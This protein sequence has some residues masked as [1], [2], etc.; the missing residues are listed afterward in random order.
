MSNIY[1]NRRLYLI[2]IILLG[3]LLRAGF[4]VTPHIDSDQ[5]IFGLQGRHILD[6]EFP[7]FSWGY[8]YMGTFQSYLDALAFYIFGSSRLVLNAVTT[9]LSILFII[10]TYYLGKALRNET[11]GI[12]GAAFAS[13]SPPYLTIHG[14]WAR[15]GYMETLLF[16]S[17]ILLITLRLTKTEGEKDRGRLLILLGFI[18]GLAFWINFLIIVFFPACGLYL[19]LKDKRLFRK[20]S[21][22][23]LPSFLS[24]S[25]PFWIYN[26]THSFSSLGMLKGG[27]K[28]PPMENLKDA[29]LIGVP[30]IIGAKTSEIMLDWP[31]YILVSIYLFSIIILT[32]IGIKDLI[33]PSPSAL[34][35]KGKGAGLILLFFLSF[36]IIF[37][38]SGFGGAIGGTRRYMLPLYSGLPFLLTFFL[39]KIRNYSKSLMIGIMVFVLGFNV[40]GNL[41]SYSFLKE[42]ELKG[43]REERRVE[44]ALFD[45]MKTEGLL[46]AYVLN[47]WLGPR[48]TFDSGEEIIF[49]QLIGDRYP[50]Y[51]RKVDE[52]SNPA[53]LLEGGIFEEEFKRLRAY[54]VKKEF[55]RYILFYSIKRSP[56]AFKEIP[57]NGWS[58]SSM[59]DGEGVK[60]TYDR[61]ITTRWRTKKAQASGMYYMI[62]MGDTYRVNKVS[63]IPGLPHDGPK[64]CRIELSLDGY[65][66]KEVVRVKGFVDFF[67]EG[68]RLKVDG[69]GRLIAIFDPI[70]ARYVR[71]TLTDGNPV[72]DW[73]ITEIFIYE[74][75]DKTQGS[76][77]KT[78][79]L[80]KGILY[81]R[82]GRLVDAVREYREVLKVNPH[83]EEA[84]HHLG[85]IYYRLG[86]IDKSP[87]E[88][89]IIFEKAGLW[90]EAAEEYKDIINILGNGSIRSLYIHLRDCYEK[91]G[92]YEGMR[93][94][95]ARLKLSFNPTRPMRIEFG[96]KILF[97]GYDINKTQ[98]KRGETFHITYYWEG[99]K[100]MDKDYASFVH[101][102]HFEPP[103]P[104]SSPLRGEGGEGVFKDSMFQH[105][106]RPLE[107]KYFKE[108][109]YK[110]N[111]WPKGEIVKEGYEVSV[112]EDI[113]SGIYKIIIGLWDTEKGER[114]KVKGEKGK[115]RQAHDK[116]EVEIGKI[117]IL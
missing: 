67:W 2:I 117:E 41:K 36:F 62:N 44:K 74:E 37:S 83:L 18:S 101:F 17:L 4:L 40:Y 49:A 110:T 65:F 90:Q 32:V 58:A 104:Q 57:V 106:H 6:G 100:K 61:E 55:G 64:G 56:T 85:R 9:F 15:H 21:L 7:I 73:A 112:P 39:F 46:H 98:I 11:T 99:L 14:A 26:I 60:N 80:F 111:K 96:E 27:V 69:S 78:Q 103:S 30:E 20:E 63:L 51:T 86:I 81:E 31:S 16:G 105:D 3:V 77:L 114:L 54:Y 84:Y 52:A 25:L 48:L 12:I 43:Y 109:G 95:D 102:K 68:N 89:G 29:F 59:P 23:I 92:D 66:W 72:Y 82:E 93:E 107:G 116:D 53:Y 42:E 113:E 94:M 50:D 115:I 88:R 87:H 1:K 19:L 28:R 22:L 38:A 35:L 91:V 34:S 33:S 75:D 13:I 45:F 24:G 97:L 5:A 76:T 10:I 70:P 108:E 71:I 79:G 8:G 47:Y